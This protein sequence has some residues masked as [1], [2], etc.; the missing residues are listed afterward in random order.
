MKAFSRRKQY[1]EDL[2]LGFLAETSRIDHFSMDIGNLQTLRLETFGHQ[3]LPAA[4][5][6]GLKVNDD[7]WW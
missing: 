2:G 7:Q 1:R 6:G 5:H 3:M 4:S